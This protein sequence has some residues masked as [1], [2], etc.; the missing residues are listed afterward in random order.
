MHGLGC[1]GTEISLDHSLYK[2]SFICLLLVRRS[3]NQMS[4]ISSLAKVKT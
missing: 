4:V 3:S 2:Y 1:R